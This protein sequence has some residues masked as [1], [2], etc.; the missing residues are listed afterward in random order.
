MVNIF[1]II[2]VIVSLLCFR[3]RRLFDRLSLKPY[4]VW[5]LKQYD[6][7]ITHGFV[8]GDLTH[9]LVNVFVFWSF[10]TFVMHAFR[11]Q[12][13]EGLS[14][15]PE[16]RFL[17]LYLGGIVAASL[18]DVIKKKDNPYYTSVGASGGVSAIV[19]TSVFLS[20]MS[21]IYLM[22]VIPMPAILFA[23][24]YI[25]YE[26]WSAKQGKGRINHHA[27]IFGAIYGFVFPILTGGF[28][29]INILL[30]GFR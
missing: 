17:L 9:L 16:I 6:R 3:N 12:Y 4:L 20:P 15:K 5:R 7:L 11:T 30:D 10:G 23:V 13:F 24:M 19:F 27:H 14:V 1:I 2:T 21:K 28:S 22:A 29:Q 18:Y 26:S 8:H 25:A